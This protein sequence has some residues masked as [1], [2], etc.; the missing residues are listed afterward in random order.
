ML[1]CVTFLFSYYDIST[2]QWTSISTV[3]IL[4]V[5]YVVLGGSFLCVSLHYDCAEAAPSYGSQYV[6]LYATHRGYDCGN[7][8]GYRKFRLGE[9]DCYRARIPGSVYRN[10]E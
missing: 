7:R 9:R 2:I 10:T 4:Q 8:N 1:R 3:A 6:Q 5:L